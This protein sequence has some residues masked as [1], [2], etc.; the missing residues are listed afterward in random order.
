MIPESNQ[1]VAIIAIGRNE[2]DRL[3]SCLRAAMAGARTVVYV[4]SGSED[5][6]AEYAASVGC[7]VVQLDPAQ[8]FSAAR[9]RNEG[10][11]CVMEHEPDVDL[12]SLSM[13]TATWLTVG[14]S[15]ASRPSMSGRMWPLPA[16]MCARS[17]PKQ[18]S[19][20]SCATWSGSRCRGR[21]ALA[22]ASSWCAPRLPRSRRLPS[23]CNC[24]RGT[25]VLRAGAACGLEDSAGGCGDGSPRC[26]DD[27][28]QPVGRR[29]LR[30]GHA[31][32][33]VAA[34][35]GKSDERYYVRDCRRIWIWGLVLPA[36][37]LCL[38]PFTYGL[39]LAAMLIL[40]ALAICPDLFRR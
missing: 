28:L 4:D 27:A 39:S 5:G 37:A 14:S 26:G 38:A 19:I 2:G 16:D 22:A 17:I 36:G 33:Q 10:F 30:S 23:R 31:Y 13:A 9:A 11:A 21:L 7:I 35:H 8:P 40:Y 18:P 24:R 25:R 15:A 6:S 20:T 3:K 12:F 34:L 29:A 32:A 1:T